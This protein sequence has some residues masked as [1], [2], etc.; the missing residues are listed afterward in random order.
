MKRLPQACA[1]ALHAPFPEPLNNLAR[2]ALSCGRADEALDYCR[3]AIALNPRFA[4]AHDNLGTIFRELG[5]LARPNKLHVIRNLLDTCISCFS[6]LFAGE[7]NYAYDLG[8][9]GRHCRHCERLM[10]HWRA[11]LPQGHM[12]QVRYEISSQTFEGGMRRML[13]YC[14]LDW[15]PACVNFHKTDRLVRTASAYQVRQPLYDNS[16]GRWRGMSRISDHSAQN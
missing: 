3:Q 14:E 2:V 8:E 1:L 16:V 13:A 7:I 9:L 11:L 12:L 5:Q 4:A 10:G 15:H 6:T